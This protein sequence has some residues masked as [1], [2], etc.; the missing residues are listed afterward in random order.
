MAA[1]L[2]KRW[3]KSE[4]PPLTEKQPTKEAPARNSHETAGEGRIM[5]KP[6]EEPWTKVLRRKATRGRVPADRLA[7][8]PGDERDGQHGDAHIVGSEAW[9]KARVTNGRS[10]EANRWM[11][12]QP[13]IRPAARYPRPLRAAA[14]CANMPKE[15]GMSVKEAMTT[16]RGRI[17]PE[18]LGVNIWDTKRTMTGGVLIEIRGPDKAQQAKKL[19]TKIEEVLEG[20]G[21]K[22]STPVKTVEIRLHRI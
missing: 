4:P 14:V 21:A 7:A 2:A 10:E 8:R 13:T 12:L 1:E 15:S 5:Q 20:S 9:T 6:V 17:D 22:I 3:A 18:N 11:P 19:A 16:V